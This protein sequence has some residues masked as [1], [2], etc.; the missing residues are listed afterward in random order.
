MTFLIADLMEPLL[1]RFG[2]FALEDEPKLGSAE[3]PLFLP[4][5]L[6]KR[7]LASPEGLGGLRV[8]RRDVGGADLFVDF[9]ALRGLG[10]GLDLLF[11]VL[12][13]A[14]LF[15]LFFALFFGLGLLLCGCGAG[16]LVL[17]EKY[18]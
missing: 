12:L 9:F 1:G 2:R 7:L 11:E 16:G 10:L 17:L 3:P 18:S 13:R 5:K 6:L 14:L 4:R 15:E 8:V